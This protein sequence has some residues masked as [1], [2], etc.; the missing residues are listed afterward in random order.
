MKNGETGRPTRAGGSEG[1]R[2]GRPGVGLKGHAGMGDRSQALG[3]VVS[4]AQ[5]NGAVGLSGFPE[6][7]SQGTKVYVHL[8]IE[9]RSA[10]LAAPRDEA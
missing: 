10:R 7:R 5:K 4:Q 3:N 9:D 2:A 8:A 6:M 1:E